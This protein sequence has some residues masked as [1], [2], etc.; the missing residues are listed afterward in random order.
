MENLNKN[1][2]TSIAL[3]LLLTISIPLLALPGANAHT[4]PWTIV[5][6]AYVSAAPDPVGVGQTLAVVMWVDTPLPGTLVDNNIRRHNYSLN[7]TKPDGTTDNQH[8]DTYLTQLANTTD[9]PLLNRQLHFQF[10]LPRR[11]IHLYS[12]EYSFTH[13][14]SRSVYKRQFYSF[15]RN[16]INYCS[17]RSDSYTL[18]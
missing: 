9:I 12:S 5:S 16:N 6:Y 1:K 7:I 14:S 2:I 18:R 17:A 15:Q 10:L 8:W 13:N 4:P 3:I 11:N